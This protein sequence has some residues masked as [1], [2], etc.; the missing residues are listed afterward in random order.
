MERDTAGMRKLAS[1]LVLE[2]AGEEDTP[3]AETAFARAVPIKKEA[4]GK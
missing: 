1:L 4:K 3:P 2:P